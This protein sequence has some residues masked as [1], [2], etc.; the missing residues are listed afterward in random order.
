MSRHGKL[1]C[2]LGALLA[3]A[4]GCAEG[5][6]C[7]TRWS[8]TAGTA[9]IVSVES[10]PWDWDQCPVAD[11]VVVRFDFT[12]TDPAR[13]ALA[14]TGW[15]LGGKPPARSWVSASGLTVGSEHPATQSG[16]PPI[17]VYLDDVD[18]AAGD[19]AC[20]APILRPGE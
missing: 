8:D 14:V 13:S 1:G 3:A 17:G 7:S 15:M 2:A 19:A 6:E 10:A 9:R 18:Y 11:P 5:P 16:A 20:G 12:P 4:S